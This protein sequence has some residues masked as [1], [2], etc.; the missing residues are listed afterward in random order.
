MGVSNIGIAGIQTFFPRLYVDVYQRSASW[1]GKN[2]AS[3]I[4]SVLNN[5]PTGIVVLNK[6]EQPSGSILS[7]SHDIIDGQQ[8]LTTLFKFLENPLV[9]T[10]D[11][12]TKG[13]QNEPTVINEV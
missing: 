7:S 12:V 2:K 8:R 11:W 3:F 5:W 4:R 10:Y 6:I 1:K 9:Y 13:P